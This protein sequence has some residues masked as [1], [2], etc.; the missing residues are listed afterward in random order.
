MAGNGHG[1]T[2]LPLS[3]CLSP[4]GTVRCLVRS[5]VTL[6]EVRVV[7]YASYPMGS[8]PADW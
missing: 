5:G 3:R 6:D 1:V 7:T 4:F 8:E 2:R